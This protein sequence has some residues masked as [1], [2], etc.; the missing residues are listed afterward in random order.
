MFFSKANRKNAETLKSLLDTYETIS[1]QLISKQ[2]SSIFFSKRT[3]DVTRTLM[4]TILGIEKEGG[5]GK[6]LGLPELFGRKK[7]DM[8]ASVVDRIKQR[9][10]SWSSK[11]LSGAGKMV[12]IKSVLSSMPSHSMTCFKLPQSVCA[13]IQSILTRFWWDSE[14][15]KH[16]MSW[17]SWENMAKPKRKGGLGFKDITSFN[18]AL[19][20]KLG[21]RILKNPTSLL[22]RCLLGKYCQSET[23][24]NCTAPS[25]AS[26]GW[27][28]VLIGRDILVK[29]LGWMV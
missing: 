10:V 3:N 14:P 18:D 5:M 25:A 8:F 19:L 11:R 2:K 20:A 1:G 22:A 16:K 27:R 7:K 15:E 13:N 9:S 21:W 12:M 4:K 29:Q 28:S 6:Y 26:H 23:F 24:L 17:I